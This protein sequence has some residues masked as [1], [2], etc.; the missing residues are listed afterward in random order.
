MNVKKHCDRFTGLLQSIIKVT[1]FGAP[2]AV[3]AMGGEAVAGG[4]MTLVFWFIVWL[5][6]L[7][8]SFIPKTEPWSMDRLMLWVI[9]LSFPVWFAWALISAINVDPKAAQ[10]R[11]EQNELL[12]SKAL[13]KFNSLCEQHAPHATKI[14]EVVNYEIPKRLFIDAPADLFGR[15]FGTQ[16]AKCVTKKMTPECSRLKLESIEWALLH[17]SSFSPCK[18]GILPGMGNCLPEYQ[19]HDLSDGNFSSIEIDQP[20]S[21]YVIRIGDAERT[22]ENSEEI[23]KYQI[24]IEARG[25]RQSFAKTEILVQSA[26][27]VSCPS[28]ENEV[29][30]MLLRVFSKP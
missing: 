21:D 1:L 10:L 13:Q 2:S 24:S 27:F 19:R 8:L 30:H 5:I 17:S 14:L 25:T 29:A 11:H 23:R 26:G 22:G 9:R 12:A 3:L 4:L 18:K 7:P 16:F 28:P 6:A 15:E 20:V